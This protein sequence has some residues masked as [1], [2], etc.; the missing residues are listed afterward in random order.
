MILEWNVQLNV[1][2][3]DLYSLKSKSKVWHL[4][5]RWFMYHYSRFEV[6]LFIIRQN[7]NFGFWK[8][9]G[10]IYSWL[11]VLSYDISY[12]H[13]KS[14]WLTKECL[15]HDPFSTFCLIWPNSI[16]KKNG[17]KSELLIWHTF[18]PKTNFKWSNGVYC[19]CWFS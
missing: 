2:E 12:I 11:C 18:A 8:F 1:Y 10:P 5:V 19:I 13:L 3:T 17:E 9:F 15:E 14:C 4:I 6:S 7:M 16:S